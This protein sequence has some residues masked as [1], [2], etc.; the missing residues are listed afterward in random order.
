MYWFRA[1]G[2][3][4]GGLF[5]NHNKTVWLASTGWPHPCKQTEVAIKTGLMKSTNLS[6]LKKHTGLIAP[7]KNPLPS[8]KRLVCMASF[9]ALW[10]RTMMSSMCV[11]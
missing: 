3:V 11:S 7:P 10:F 1:R 8:F 6:L 9:W 4:L 5:F 2:Y